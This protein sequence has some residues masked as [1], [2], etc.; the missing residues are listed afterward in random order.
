[1]FFLFLLMFAVMFPNVQLCAVMFAYV[2]LC[3]SYFCL[4]LP[5]CVHRKC[6]QDFFAAVL[7]QLEDTLQEPELLRVGRD[8]HPPN[9]FVIL[10]TT[11]MNDNAEAYMCCAC[12]LR[13]P[14]MRCR[15]CTISAATMHQ[16]PV[17]INDMNLRDGEYLAMLTDLSEEP[18]LKSMTKPLNAR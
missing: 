5:V 12:N 6:H 9:K 17:T 11:W 1:M 16:G 14:L 4:C 15:K 18:F 8:D 10:S 7:T 3:F 13:S 2:P